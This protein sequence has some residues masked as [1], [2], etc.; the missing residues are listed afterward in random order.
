MRNIAV[1]IAGTVLVPFI[2]HIL[3]PYLLLRATSGSAPD[4]LGP[5][6]VS[7]I[8]LAVIGISMIIWVST[9]FVRRGN[10][11][12]APV[13][14][15]KKFV[16]VGLFR[17]VR[18]PMY[19]GILLVIVAEAIFFR[20]AWLLLYASLL[21]LAAHSFVVLI[22]EPQLEKRFGVSYKDY[23]KRTPRWIPRPPSH[24]GA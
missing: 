4:Q 16:A 24:Q 21:W 9:T 19:V 2:V 13:L 17:F 22:E 1:T 10:G 6:E 11:T 18:N 23:V 5:V 14:P 7:S 20:S 15:P 3:V 8:V 12:A